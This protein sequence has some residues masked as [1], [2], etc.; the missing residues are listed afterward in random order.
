MTVGFKP[1]MFNVQTLISFKIIILKLFIKI[2]F[3]CPHSELNRRP[4]AYKA[5]ALPTELCGLAYNGN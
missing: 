3:Y 4:S 5:G 1:F 2:C